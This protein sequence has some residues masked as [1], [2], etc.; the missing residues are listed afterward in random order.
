MTGD[1]T[2]VLKAVAQDQSGLCRQ[3][4]IALGGAPGLLSGASSSVGIRVPFAY[5]PRNCY[6]CTNHSHL[7]TI[8]SLCQGII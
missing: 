1:A 3:V 5:D 7:G 8:L 4:D 6:T 2:Q